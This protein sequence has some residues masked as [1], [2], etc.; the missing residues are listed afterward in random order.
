MEGRESDGHEFKYVHSYIS[1]SLSQDFFLLPF[2][3]L[4]TNYMCLLFSLFSTHFYHFIFLC[5]FGGAV[6]EDAG[7]F[8]GDLSTWD[9]GNVTTMYYSTY[10][11]LFFSSSI[12]N[13]VFFGCFIFPFSFLYRAL[14]IFLTMIWCSVSLCWYI[15]LWSLHME[16][17]ESD[18]HARQY[19]HSLY[20]PLSSQQDRGFVWIHMFLFFFFLFCA[21]ISFLI[22]PLFPPIFIIGLFF[23][24]VVQCLT[25][26][27]HSMVISPHGKSEKWQP[28]KKV[29]TKLFPPDLIFF[30]NL[31]SLFF[32]P[33]LT[34]DFSLLLC[35]VSRC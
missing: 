11:L 23:V 27:M 18:R 2:L 15:Q 28:C 13:R 20:F 30:W 24:A 14:I 25:V 35:S 19:V 12:R 31:F 5:Y 9:V 16:R 33:F 34:L 1:P 6:F 8:N 17:R 7:D 21:L 26:L 10:T 22:S 29:R 3:Y 32:N 4:C